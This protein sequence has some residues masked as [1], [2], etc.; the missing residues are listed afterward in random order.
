LE[1]IIVATFVCDTAILAVGSSNVE[2][3]GKLQTAIHEIQKWTKKWH[4]QLNK[5]KSVH[6]NFSNRRFEH[7]PVTINNQKLPCANTAKYLGMTLD[8]KRR[9]K[10]YAKKETRGTGP[11]IQKKSIG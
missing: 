1:N 5:S 9:W 10:D 8:S 11:K 7:I 3:T 6:I 2:S 4:I